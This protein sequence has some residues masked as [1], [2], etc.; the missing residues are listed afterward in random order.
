ML[1]A[2][3][4]AVLS[5]EHVVYVKKTSLDLRGTAIEKFRMLFN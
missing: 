2:N 3:L 4:L 1:D 5:S